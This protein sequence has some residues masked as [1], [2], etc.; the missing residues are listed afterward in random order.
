MVRPR[1]DAPPAADGPRINT[2][3]GPQL[4]GA[5]I[6]KVNRWDSDNR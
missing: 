2:E 6:L 4:S 5:S 1:N 3:I